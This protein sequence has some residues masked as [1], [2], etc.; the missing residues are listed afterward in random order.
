[1]KTRVIAALALVLAIALPVQS[2]AQWSL[3]THGGYD[4]DA[5]EFLIGASVEFSIPGAAISGVPLTFVPGFDYYPGIDGVS[6]FVMDF[7]AHYPI[8]AKGLTP[9]IGGGMYVSRVSVDIPPFGNVSDTNFG[10]NLKGGATFGTSSKVRPFGEGRL[11][12]GN[13]STFILKGGL[14]IQLGS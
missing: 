12:V 13:G 6:F 5:K 9:Y 3:N 7:D 8:Q 1:M 10:L 11:R 2:H 4:L 14:S